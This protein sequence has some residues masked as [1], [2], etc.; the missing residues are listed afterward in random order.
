[1]AQLYGGA[2]PCGIGF[3]MSLFTGDLAFRGSPRG[4]EVE[5]AVFVGSL[6]PAAARLAV[7]AAV[8]R[9]KGRVMVRP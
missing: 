7:L 5:L 2:V 8:S 1:M 9:V 4:D 3:T 6:L